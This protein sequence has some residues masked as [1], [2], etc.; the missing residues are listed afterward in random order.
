MVSIKRIL[1]ALVPVI[2]A[3]SRAI[4][5]V[6]ILSS[7]APPALISSSQFHEEIL[8]AADVLEREGFLRT[9]LPPRPQQGGRRITKEWLNGLGDR[10]CLWRFRCVLKTSSHLLLLMATMY[11]FTAQELLELS[12]VLRLPS[13]IIT[14][15]RYRVTSLEALGLTCARFA[16]AYDIFD[17]AAMYDRS[18][19]AI[20][21]IVNYTVCAI[22]M[23]W[24]RLLD[25]DHTHL[26]S[27]S[28]LASYA[29]AVH[30]AGAPLSTV[31]GFLDCTLRR[32]ARPVRYQQAAYSGYKKNHSLKYQ[33]V[34]VPNGMIAHLFGPYEGRHAD[35]YLLAESGLLEKCMEHAIQVDSTAGSPIEQRYYQLFGDPAYGL[36]AQLISPFSGPGVRSELEQEWNSQMAHVRIKVE[37]AFGGVVNNWPFLNAFWKLRVHSSPVGRYY[38]VAVLLTN[39]LNCFRPN[40][41]ALAFDCP[42][43][44][45][46]EYF[47]D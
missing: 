42:P 45:L 9:T 44:L 14:R 43:P 15:S 8:A 20:S 31:W 29:A 25:F 5:F 23:A 36:S 41:V 38:R 47:H 34:A 4:Q 1:A 3:P 30:A 10:D 6:S 27:P 19:S 37:H 11:R 46:H 24:S 16:R 40:Q 12:N 28:N 13:S 26:L 17:L 7:R 22:D 2:S 39:A 32:I 35:P 33:A 18:E 21:E